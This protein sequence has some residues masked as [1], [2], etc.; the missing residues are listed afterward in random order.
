MSGF[1]LAGIAF[2]SALIQ[3]I[4]GFGFSL[5]AMPLASR[6]LGVQMAGPIVALTAL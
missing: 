2:V 3:N 4:A 5:I 6:I 1:L